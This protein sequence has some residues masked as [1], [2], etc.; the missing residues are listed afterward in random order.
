MHAALPLHSVVLSD[1]RTVVPKVPDTDQTDAGGDGEEF[2]DRSPLVRAIS[3]T[4]V[5]IEAVYAPPRS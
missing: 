3:D 1:V 4:V 5:R 2:E